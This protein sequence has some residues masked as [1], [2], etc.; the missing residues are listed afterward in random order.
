M[1]F[2]PS[3]NRID[4]TWF[5]IFHLSE[6]KTIE[7][8]DTFNIVEMLQQLMTLTTS[9]Y[10]PRPYFVTSLDAFYKCVT[11]AYEIAP[12]ATQGL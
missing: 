8:W 6:G 5:G 11:R 2:A 9:S 7:S 10:V 12:I 4:V 1:D 3:S